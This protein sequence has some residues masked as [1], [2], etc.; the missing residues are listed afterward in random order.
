MKRRVGLAQLNQLKSLHIPWLTFASNF[1]RTYPNGAVAGNLIG[2]FG[3]E[4]KPQAGIELS[5]DTCLA[6]KDGSEHYE[7]SADGVALPGSMVRKRSA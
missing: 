4:G 1:S 2:F 6:G 5:Q 3:H 7:R